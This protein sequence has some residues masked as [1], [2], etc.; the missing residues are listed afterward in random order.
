MEYKI[1]TVAPK[2]P[3]IQMRDND[4]EGCIR[5]NANDWRF[6]YD[7]ELRRPPAPVIWSE[8]L[9]GSDP[10]SQRELLTGLLNLLNAT[11]PPKKKKRK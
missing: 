11:C 5:F 6:E 2:S 1:V 7:A 4:V 3:D 9:D 10:D 8:W